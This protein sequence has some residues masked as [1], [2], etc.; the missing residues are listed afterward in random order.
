MMNRYIVLAL[1][2][3]LF[4]CS[5]EQT[6]TEVYS[7]IYDT[8]DPLIAIPK[9]NELSTFMELADVSKEIIVRYRE[10]TSID[11][12]PVKQITRKAEQ[13]GLFANQVQEKRQTRAFNNAITQLLGNVDT[14]SVST[15]SS[16]F[17]PVLNELKT[18]S[19]IKSTNRKT[20][21]L[22][23]DLMDNNEWISFYRQTDKKGLYAQ[24]KQLVKLFTDKLANIQVDESIRIIV[25]YQPRDVHDNIRYKHLRWLWREVFTS[26]NIHIS[27]SANLNDAY[28]PL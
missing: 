16:V 25:I 20:L 15:H 19:N 2:S 28:H 3:I 8:T 9:A 5:S 1:I 13:T 12:T 21:I 26:R 14:T 24:S 10:C 7:I 27:F 4:G 17:V 18:L 23:S 6:R 22:Y 11:I